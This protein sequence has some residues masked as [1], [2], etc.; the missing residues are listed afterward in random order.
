MIKEKLNQLKL[1]ELREIAKRRNIDNYSKMTKKELIDVLSKKKESKKPII[2]KTLIIVTVFVLGVIF[3]KNID[4]MSKL[5][6]GDI[7]TQLNKSVN[8]YVDIIN[9]D[10]QK[11]NSSMKLNKDTIKMAKEGDIQ[12][13]H[14]LQYVVL[15]ESEDEYISWIFDSSNGE[16]KAFFINTAH[17]ENDE[18]KNDVVLMKELVEIHKNKIGQYKDEIINKINSGGSDYIVD[19]DLTYYQYFVKNNLEEGYDYAATYEIDFFK[20]K[21]DTSEQLDVG[22]LEE[23]EVTEKTEGDGNNE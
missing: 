12:G 4:S 21:A 9:K 3:G 8:M 23:T 20:Y 18:N 16:L 22:T 19:D 14:F 13:F 5:F 7:N 17:I 10:L 15:S 2:I 11:Q 1:N 6:K